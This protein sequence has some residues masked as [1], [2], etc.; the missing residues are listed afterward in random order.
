M[1]V[2]QPSSNLY[3]EESLRS[4]RLTTP[5]TFLQKFRPILLKVK[6]RTETDAEYLARTA[7]QTEKVPREQTFRE[8]ERKPE[9]FTR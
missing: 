9:D 1:Y 6:V 4:N 3:K 8:S 2:M 7:R 5:T